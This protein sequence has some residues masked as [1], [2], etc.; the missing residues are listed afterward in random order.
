MSKKYVKL[1]KNDVFSP[2][3]C[4][5]RVA[6]CFGRS[7]SAEI[8]RSFGQSFGFGRT[9]PIFKQKHELSHYDCLYYVFLLVEATVCELKL[10]VCISK[11]GF[12]VPTMS[13]QVNLCM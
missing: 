8:D 10:L 7:S 9:L 5:G 2:I 13:Y 1:A 4:F 11:E 6:E 12:K 3:R